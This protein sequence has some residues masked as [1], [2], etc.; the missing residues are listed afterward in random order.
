MLQMWKNNSEV[1][2]T[3]LAGKDESVMINNFEAAFRLLNCGKS[4]MKLRYPEFR[5]KLNLFFIDFDF[6]PLLVQEC[7][8]GC[9]QDRKSNDD[10]E[11]MA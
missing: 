2:R 7:Y 5:Q 3:S 10:I 4:E 8:L 1:V 9:F 6:I 11:S